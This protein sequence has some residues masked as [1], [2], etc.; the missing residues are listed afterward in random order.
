MRPY[1]MDFTKLTPACKSLWC[2]SVI[3]TVDNTNVQRLWGLL[4]PKL[5]TEP[6]SKKC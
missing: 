5:Q 2:G 3:A 6:R 1:K 4:N